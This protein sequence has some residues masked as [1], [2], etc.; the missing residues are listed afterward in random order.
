MSFTPEQIGAAIAFNACVDPNST[1]ATYLRLLTQI[2]AKADDLALTPEEQNLPQEQAQEVFTK[3]IAKAIFADG[4]VTTQEQQL[5]D[6]MSQLK[7][8]KGLQ[9]SLQNDIAALAKK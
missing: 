5:L 4:V 3:K 8:D 7:E 2:G 1:L 9:E 6:F